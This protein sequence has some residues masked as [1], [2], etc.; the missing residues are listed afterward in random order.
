MPTTLVDSHASP[1]AL[2]EESLRLVDTL[3]TSTEDPVENTFAEKQQ[4]LLPQVLYSSWT[5]PALPGRPEGRKFWAASDV[6]IFRHTKESPL[7]P[8]TFVALDVMPPIHKQGAYFCWDTHKM[9]DLVVEVVSNRE[10]NELGSKLSTYALWGVGYYA[11][12]DPFHQ[13][14]DDELQ[15]FVLED[16]KYRLMEVPF[17]PRLG[18]GLT[19]WHGEFEGATATYLRWCDESGALLLTADERLASVC[20]QHAEEVAEAK[21]DAEEAKSEAAQAKFQAARAERE[22][23]QAKSLAEEALAQAARD[24][25]DRERLAAKLRALG[26]DPEQ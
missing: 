9:P 4:R 5:P 12:Y 17:L 3:V 26:I 10:G 11:V 16:G 7:V 24:R 19:L 6:G 13:L 22:A 18:L 23:A 8:D 21:S 14:T 20:V 2:D 25:Q 15:V 1:F